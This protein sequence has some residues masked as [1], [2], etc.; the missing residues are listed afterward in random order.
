[1]MPES[2]AAIMAVANKFLPGPSADADTASH[3]G[4]QSLSE[5]A[6]SRLTALSDRAAAENNEVPQS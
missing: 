2:T 4:W 3:S 5:W 6:P 1:L